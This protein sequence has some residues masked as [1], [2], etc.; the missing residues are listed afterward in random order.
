MIFFIL[1]FFVGYFLSFGLVR[2]RTIR[3]SACAETHIECRCSCTEDITITDVII[4]TP[5]RKW[6]LGVNDVM[7]GSDGLRIL[8]IFKKSRELR[9]EPGWGELIFG[10]GRGQSSLGLWDAL[11]VVGSDGTVS[12]LKIVSL[13]PRVENLK[14]KFRTWTKRVV[15]CFTGFLCMWTFY[16]SVY[17]TYRILKMLHYGMDIP[18]SLT[19][20]NGVWKYMYLSC[21]TRDFRQLLTSLHPLLGHFTHEDKNTY[22]K[23][24]LNSCLSSLIK[25]AYKKIF[26]QNWCIIY[27]YIY[28]CTYVCIHE[29]I[30]LFFCWSKER[31][32]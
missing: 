22:K 25:Y 13:S 15:N 26:C 8:V 18:I 5:D 4:K 1:S 16:I 11:C 2:L 10:P 3:L 23:S 28:I 32:K 29:K 21:N 6:D 19:M 12:I 14:V 7:P 9:F 31:K 24:M 20:T 27:I 30:F 17:F